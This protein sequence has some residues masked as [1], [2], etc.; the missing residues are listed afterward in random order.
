M[1]IWA[2]ARGRSQ[3]EY[4]LGC[5]LTSRPYGIELLR[6]SAERVPGE[7]IDGYVMNWAN[8]G[9]V[10]SDWAI[11]YNEGLRNPIQEEAHRRGQIAR[12]YLTAPL[13]IT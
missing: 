1:T 4:D 11:G 3:M 10:G 13:A 12:C 6:P 5:E 9:F 8:T 7:F 2:G